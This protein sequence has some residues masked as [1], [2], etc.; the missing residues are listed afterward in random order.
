MKDPARYF[1]EF[2]W[3]ETKTIVYPL[4]LLADTFPLKKK[5]KILIEFQC[6]EHDK[7]HSSLKTIP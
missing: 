6:V 1:N 7:N 2:D 4:N 5:K 3:D